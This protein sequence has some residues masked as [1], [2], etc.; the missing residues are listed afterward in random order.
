MWLDPLPDEESAGVIA[1]GGASAA[2][3]GDAV[4]GGVDGLCSPLENVRRRNHTVHCRRP[5][6]YAAKAFA[7]GDSAPAGVAEIESI[8]A[9][10]SVGNEMGLFAY[11]EGLL[12]LLSGIIV[13]CRFYIGLHSITRTTCVYSC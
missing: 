7:K 11:L 2:D 8:R 5:T 9:R 4:S 10:V 3:S 6:Y 13:F 1:G 12:L